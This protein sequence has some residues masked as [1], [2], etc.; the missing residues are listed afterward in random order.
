VLG[1]PFLRRRKSSFIHGAG[2]DMWELAAHLHPHLDRIVRQANVA[3][4]L[5]AHTAAA[6]S[7]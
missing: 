3:F 6:N 4:P 5:A 2:D 7:I 1:L